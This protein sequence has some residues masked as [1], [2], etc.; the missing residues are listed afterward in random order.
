MLA[1]NMID[2]DGLVNSRDLGGLR[3]VDGGVTRTGVLYRG[4][5]PQL[6]SPA[7]VEKACHDLGIGL[8]V[9]L[10][11]VS[12]ALGA[13]PGGS[14]PLGEAVDRVNLDFVG[15]AGGVDAIGVTVDTFFLSLLEVGARPLEAFLEL[16]TQSEAPV[17]VHCH[18][19]K[20]RTGFVVAMT[21]A[22]A[23]VRD[24]EIIADYAMTGPIFEKMMNNLERRGM[25]VLPEAPAF[26][27]HP[28]SVE[29][30]A[31][32][33]QQVNA[34]W[35]SASAWALAHGIPQRLIDDTRARLAD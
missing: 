32:L 24:D 31:E 10:R 18:T 3:L 21:L 25:P 27:H 1:R 12:R 13:L 15:L 5:T 4:E 30:M 11:G 6:M 22:L 9:D 8:V 33:L 34:R 19:G 17:L 26:A 14:G 20:D 29:S 7:D 2:F 16:F 23:G 35:G 28:P